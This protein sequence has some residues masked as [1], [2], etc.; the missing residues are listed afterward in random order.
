MS[1]TW[2]KVENFLYQQLSMK[3]KLFIYILHI[4]WLTKISL[5][6]FQHTNV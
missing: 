3:I 4:W 1:S 2:L 5:G 6:S